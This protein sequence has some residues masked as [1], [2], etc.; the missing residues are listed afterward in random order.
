MAGAGYKVFSPGE[1]LLANDVNQYLM[2]QSI[3]VFAGT[4]ARSSA[5]TSPSEGMVTYLTDTN[6]LRYYNGTAWLSP[7]ETTS[8]VT[9]AGDLVYGTASGAMTRL[10]IGTSG[11]VLKVNSGATAPEWGTIATSS[12]TSLASGSLGTATTSITGI[13]GSYRN[14][15]LVVRNY[16]PATDNTDQRLQFNSD[17]GSNYRGGAYPNQSNITSA[18]FLVCNANPDNG[19]ANGLSII[20]IPEYTNTSAYKQISY[21]AHSRN[22]S[23]SSNYDV[24]TGIGVWTS[25]SAI[26]SIQLFAGTGNT[27]SGT[28]EL[29]GIV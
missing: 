17:T 8:L 16:R 26:T 14:L 7:D 5:I 11:Q 19:T 2:E 1:V 23:S 10:G 21:I 13:S 9:A 24:T 28:Y 3:M 27:T 29:L 18:T 25:G 20:E 12:I 22:A 6:Q 15:V 4:A